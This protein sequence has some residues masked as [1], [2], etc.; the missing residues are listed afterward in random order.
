MTINNFISVSEPNLIQTRICKYDILNKPIIFFGH[1][2]C[3]VY[4]WYSLFQVMINYTFQ[5]D[6][7]V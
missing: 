2:L 4:L 5:D 6:F 3:M 1:G 7:V